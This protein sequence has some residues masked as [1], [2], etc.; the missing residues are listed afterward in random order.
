MYEASSEAKNTKALAISSGFPRRRRG[1]FAV[2]GSRT[3]LGTAFIM[4]VCVMPG[5][6]AFT[7]IPF[8]PSSRAKDTVSPFTANLDAGYAKPL[9]WPEMLTIDEVERITPLPLATMHSAAAR[10]ALKTPFHIQ[11]HDFIESLLCVLH[12][13][14]TLGNTCVVYQDVHT[15]IFLCSSLKHF[16]D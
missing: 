15:A 2:N 6:T 13:W 8:G 1:M 7:R 11:I 9:G 12:K 14:S 16:T 4:S 5:A 10:V 3:S